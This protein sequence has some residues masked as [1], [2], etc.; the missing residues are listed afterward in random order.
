MS[1]SRTALRMATIAALTNGGVPPWPTMAQ[2]RLFDSRED[3][4]Q[5]SD[6]KDLLPL[7][8]VFTDE[9]KGDPQFGREQGGPPFRRHI[10]LY[11]EFGLASDPETGM[12]PP[13]TGELEALL[14]IFEWQIRAALFAPTGIWGPLWL[15]TA[16]GVTESDC[17]RYVHPE[18]GQRLASRLLKLTC[19]VSD[20]CAGTAHVVAPG[21]T[22]PPPSIPNPLAAVLDTI[23]A[24][25]DGDTKA[26]AGRVRAVVVAG[27]SDPASAPPFAGYTINW[28][29]ST[30]GQPNGQTTT[31]AFVA[32]DT[33]TS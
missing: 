29:A 21:G 7:I 32:G 12:P 22:A 20:D 28:P 10:D 30:A 27:L 13:T 18:G 5:Y 2:N 26:L 9:D 15:E 24:K 33:F 16:L 31:P 25:G 6:R 4:L 23:D 17:L 1:L 3:P 8:S 11:L 19:K 14:D